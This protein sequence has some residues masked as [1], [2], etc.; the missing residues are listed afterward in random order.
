MTAP[1]IRHQS[2]SASAGSGKTFALA[3]RYLR[4]LAL[5]VPSDRICALTFSRKAA[6]EIFESVVERLCLAATNDE[7]AAAT[8]ARLDREG[9]TRGDFRAWLREFIENLHRNHIGT[10]D[11]FI[12]GIIRNFPTE[13]G[14][15]I[16]FAV[17]DGDGAEA[18]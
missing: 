16:D 10:L 8:G 6:G 1:G 14:V 12:I 5:G 3:H 13:V 9:V 11:S 18:A 17:M 2:I 15:P 7:D 4:L